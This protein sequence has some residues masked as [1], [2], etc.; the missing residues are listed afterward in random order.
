MEPEASQTA[1]FFL[2]TISLITMLTI[3][4]NKLLNLALLCETS[5][6]KVSNHKLYVQG[7]KNVNYAYRNYWIKSRTLIQVYLYYKSREFCNQ[8]NRSRPLV[9]VY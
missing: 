1:G 5:T 9:Q 2:P 3:G 7:Y 8:K 6:I 4:P